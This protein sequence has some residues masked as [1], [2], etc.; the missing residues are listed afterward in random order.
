MRW[1]ATRFGTNYMFLESMF[2]RKDKF[3]AWMSSPG[4]LESKFSSTQEERY[5]HC[6]LS[7]LTW[8]D[9]MQYV[10]KG[11]SYAH[12]LFTTFRWRFLIFLS[13]APFS[14]M[15]GYVWRRH[16]FPP[17]ASTTVCLSMLLVHG[18][19]WCAIGVWVGESKIPL[20]VGFRMANNRRMDGANLGRLQ[21]KLDGKSSYRAHVD[22]WL[23]YDTLHL[24]DASMSSMYLE[25]M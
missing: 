7:N 2:H 21:G 16:T 22:Q 10:L 4:F 17:G 5:A 23:L 1:N 24:D 6:S 9:T 20:H 3:I 25:L 15:V 8:S 11:V 12:T 13:L 19:P 18:R 14:T